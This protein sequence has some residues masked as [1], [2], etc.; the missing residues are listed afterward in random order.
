[1]L[2]DVSSGDQRTGAEDARPLWLVCEDGA[3]YLDRFRRF[4]DAEFRFA[5]APDAATLL[6]A[7]AGEAG[8]GVGVILDLDFRRTPPEHLVDE[9]G[10]SGRGLPDEQR[11]RL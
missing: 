11:R 6:S 4:L 2:P 5:P 1:M 7:L 10:R 8:A 9:D 3:E